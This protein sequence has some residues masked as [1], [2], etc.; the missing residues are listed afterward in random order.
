MIVQLTNICNSVETADKNAVHLL[1]NDFFSLASFSGMQNTGNQVA[2]AIVGNAKLVQDGYD[3]VVTADGN[4]LY[5][6]LFSDE[7]LNMQQFQKLGTTI[8]ANALITLM[9]QQGW[10]TE[11]TYH[12]AHTVD[13][14]ITFAQ[15]ADAYKSTIDGNRQTPIHTDNASAV[16]V[17]NF[18][19][20]MDEETMY[21]DGKKV[22]KYVL[23]V[24]LDVGTLTADYGS[25]DHGYHKNGHAGVDINAP[26][27]TPIG[28]AT[29]GE[30]VGVFNNDTQGYRGYGNSVL[31]KGD[32]GN[33]YF[34]AHMS[35]VDVKVGDTVSCGE[36]LGGVGNTG[37][38]TGN[39]LH[40]EVRAGGEW[41]ST[42]LN[43]HDFIDF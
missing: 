28:S 13:T 35:S 36:S 6:D 11:A 27:G 34:Y 29:S 10:S 2:D 43:P 8:G 16:T 17:T 33:Y 26:W 40:F 7:T 41:N 30:V 37:Q 1:T 18:M 42:K 24:N 3:Y 20:G 14:N 22:S 4:K 32:D 12:A 9:Q 5:L 19:S 38:S 25:T 31:V 23:P 39:H 15:V 21:I